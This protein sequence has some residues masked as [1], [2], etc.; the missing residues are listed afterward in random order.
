MIHHLLDNPS[1]N[2]NL[3]KL[4]FSNLINSDILSEAGHYSNFVSNSLVRFIKCFPSLKFI[5]PCE[6]WSKGFSS[7]DLLGVLSQLQQLNQDV[8]LNYQRLNHSVLNLHFDI[9][10]MNP[11]QYRYVV[12]K[13]RIPESQG[14]TRQNTDSSQPI[15]TGQDNSSDMTSEESALNHD[16]DQ[17]EWT[18][19]QDG[20]LTVYKAVN[21]PTQDTDTM[22]WK[23]E[24]SSS[25]HSNH[26]SYDKSKGEEYDYSESFSKQDKHQTICIKDDEQSRPNS[27]IEMA[28]FDDDLCVQKD[29]GGEE[30]PLTFVSDAVVNQLSGY[31][32]S[33]SNIIGLN[34][35]NSST[36]SDEMTA[37]I[38]DDPT[39]DFYRSREETVRKENVLINDEFSRSQSSNKYSNEALDEDVEPQSSEAVRSIVALER[40][41]SYSPSRDELSKMLIGRN[42]ADEPENSDATLEPCEQVIKDDTLPQSS[43]KEKIDIHV[44]DNNDVKEDVTTQVENN[45]TTKE[46]DCGIK[47]TLWNEPLYPECITDINYISTSETEPLL[48]ESSLIPKEEIFEYEPNKYDRYNPMTPE[49]SAPNYLGNDGPENVHT[50][51]GTQ[52]LYQKLDSSTENNFNSQNTE[53]QTSLVR[54][55]KEID[56]R[57]E[58]ISKMPKDEKIRKD[59]DIENND[60]EDYSDEQAW[61]WDYDENTWKLWDDDWDDED[62]EYLDSDEEAF[63]DELQKK[64]NQGYVITKEDYVMGPLE[65]YVE[66]VKITNENDN[67]GHKD[68]KTSIIKSDNTISQNKDDQNMKMVDNE[69]A[70][71][72]VPHHQNSHTD[73]Y[74]A[75]LSSSTEKMKH[76]EDEFDVNSK[77]DLIP[78]S[79]MIGKNVDSVDVCQERQQLPQP[80]TG[81]DHISVDNNEISEEN[82]IIERNNTSKDQKHSASIRLENPEAVRKNKRKDGSDLVQE[83]IFAEHPDK[84]SLDKTNDEDISNQTEDNECQLII[85]TITTVCMWGHENCKIDSH[86]KYKWQEK[87]TE[88]V[89]E[90]ELKSDEIDEKEPK[91]L[92][93]TNKSAKSKTNFDNVKQ[94][95]EKANSTKVSASKS[96]DIRSPI[97]T[98]TNNVS[99]NKDKL[100]LDTGGMGVTKTLEMLKGQ[101]NQ[102]GKKD[103]NSEK[104]QRNYELDKMKRLRQA[105]VTREY[106]RS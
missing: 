99:M 78:K 75:G 88:L 9:Q 33:V 103:G 14:R 55:D 76:H 87:Q 17:F 13:G 70:I 81:T 97:C 57:K 89:K 26:L 106:L 54:I 56:V 40:E 48:E 45:L 18:W 43:A 79:E 37:E 2:P 60:D 24:L 90:P 38:L 52:K 74:L 53:T 65:K 41:T 28:S 8:I 71:D 3:R 105:G 21:E 30:D 12:D 82:V 19:G 92:E 83:P 80:I 22:D 32:G 66:T 25:F 44:S 94:R 20:R 31:G 50:E 91:T 16:I 86:F 100:R 34:K 101:L 46:R 42:E 5:G 36:L 6:R 11:W 62:Y 58:N 61:Y 23:N 15:H 27:R 104:E 72:F 39:P 77:S 84:D 102:A 35:D 59:D 63:C 29:M 68:I 10:T 4:A 67:T 73:L 96:M 1:C 7:S 98:S 47:Q 85:T 93:L 64:K 69:E 95:W 51:Q 49:C